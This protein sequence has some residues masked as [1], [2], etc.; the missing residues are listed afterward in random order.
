MR[1][2]NLITKSLLFASIVTILTACSGGIC[3]TNGNSS[4]AALSISMSA[5][6]EYPAGFA[7][8]IP[9]LVTN[10]GKA[11]QD[12]LSYQII[13]NNTQSNL[14][15]DSQSLTNCR[16]I[17]TGGSCTLNV[18]VPAGSKPGSFTVATASTSST[19]KTTKFLAS[20]IGAQQMQVNVNIGLTQLS[21]STE[22]GLAGVSLFYNKGLSLA[23]N[24]SGVAIITM[25]VNSPNVGAFNTL[26]LLD[27]SGNQLKYDVLTGNSGMGLS[28]LAYGSVVSL[29]V[30]IPSGATQL[31][32]KPQLQLDNTPLSNG[33]SSSLSSIAVLR[34]S[35]PAQALISVLPSNFSL[36]ES[37]SNQTITLVNNGTGSAT[38]TSP[39]LAAP[40]SIGGNSTCGSSLAVGSSCQYVINLYTASKQAGTSP[41]VLNYNDG[42]HSSSVTSTFTYVGKNAIANL[43]IASGTNPNFNF[44]STTSS[45]VE[46]ALITLSNTGA[47]TIGLE[48]FNPP[49]Y[50]SIS[51]AGVSNP[52]SNNMDL[53][54][55][56]S[57]NVSLMYT[58]PV[59]TS[60]QT[61]QVALVNYTYQDMLDPKVT[62]TG[63]SSVGL[64]YGTLQSQA[65][66]SVSSGS[67]NF[68]S[69]VNNDVES[70][71]Q[72]ILI[73]N[74]GDAS[75]S[76]VP[77]FNF[78]QA[79]SIYSIVNNTC[80][81]IL[82]SGESCVVT[83]KSGPVPATTTAGAQTNTLNISY[84]PYAGAA[85]ATANVN[86]N[87]QVA[88]AQSAII[89]I[90]KTAT[91]GFIAGTDGTAAS[92]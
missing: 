15:F 75:T 33:T 78:T 55:N 76:S 51:T 57:C 82:L 45:P 3:L 2:S 88:T 91:S 81:G 59:A 48:S 89:N 64:T 22:S 30:T 74:I 60:A 1:K 53:N 36:N 39:Q 47:T 6:S 5:P 41:F 73:T 61:T 49:E 42:I 83:I 18:M 70:S 66:L 7:G 13:N 25:V 92:P 16:T 50:F 17:A 63:S 24:N 44:Q 54:V 9:V 52:C 84:I 14:T 46:S 71:V 72:D 56:Q 12:N 62:L 29:A 21:N 79:A 40:M 38:L 20:L 10:T 90:A 8:T 4:L 87:T 23:D 67:V 19:N 34:P 27:S 11:T 86:L 35:S 77:I 26:A 68:T 31:S 37:S 43:Q 69:L 58:N 80:N 32:F 28:N 65:N 85:T